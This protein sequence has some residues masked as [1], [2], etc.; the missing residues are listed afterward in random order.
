VAFPAIST[1]IF[2]YPLGPAARIAVEA[3]RSATA[4]PGPIRQ[5]IFACF[6]SDV[7]MA[8]RD[9]GIAAG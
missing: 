9:E 6:S 2:G 7:F 5:M 1:G 8:Y 4:R 3:V